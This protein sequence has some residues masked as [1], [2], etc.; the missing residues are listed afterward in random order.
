MIRE[1]WAWALFRDPIPCAIAALSL[2][3]AGYLTEVIAGSLRAVP[4]GQVEAGLALGL[5][6]RQVFRFIKVPHALR[7]GYPQL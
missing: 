3:S 2:N 1:T 4:K 6:P 7:A 5:S